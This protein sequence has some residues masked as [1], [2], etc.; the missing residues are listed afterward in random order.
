MTLL[1]H[2]PHRLARRQ[3]A[4][5]AAAAVAVAVV[6]A[7]VVVVIVVVVVVA[8]VAVAVLG[9]V[10]V[11]VLRAVAV[12]VLVLMQLRSLNF[13]YRCSD[14]PVGLPSLALCCAVLCCALQLAFWTIL[15]QI[16]FLN[17]QYTIS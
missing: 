2:Q 7:L 15:L 6:V 16:L 4:P 17:F 3:H 11:A 13:K 12:A 9:A 14:F 10:V 5:A 1:L 8:A